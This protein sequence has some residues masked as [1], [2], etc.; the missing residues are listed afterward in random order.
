MEIIISLTN[1][2]GKVINC[3][4]YNFNNL[5]EFN[6]VIKS[7]K[8]DVLAKYSSNIFYTRISSLEK[9]TINID[10]GSHRYFINIHGV[11]LKIDIDNDNVRKFNVVY[12]DGNYTICSGSHLNSLLID[13]SL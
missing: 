9:D 13:R 10:F 4:E 8:D 3:S 7:F 12:K 2:Q 11:G 5:E 1:S 6:R